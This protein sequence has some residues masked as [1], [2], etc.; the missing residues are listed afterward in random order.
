[1]TAPAGL[2][3]T[4]VFIAQ[5]Q[6][7][8]LRSDLIPDEAFVSVVTL[9]ELQAGVLAAKRTDDR[10]ARLRT[11]AVVTSREPLTVTTQAAAQWARL[12]VRLAEG[13]RRIP[14]D[15]LWIAAIAAANDLPI[16]TQDADFDALDDLDLIEVIRV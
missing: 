3:D 2:L 10:A 12:R 6:D 4:S 7:R 14:V 9:A 8:A 15:D 11:L 16:V 1:M 13:D 5:E